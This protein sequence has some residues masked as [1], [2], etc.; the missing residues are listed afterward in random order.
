MSLSQKASSLTQLIIRDVVGVFPGHRF[1]LRITQTI[2]SYLAL[3]DMMRLSF[4]C[5]R[6]YIILGD[7]KILKRFQ[8]Y[9]SPKH[10][11]KGPKKLKRQ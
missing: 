8:E 9:N 11:T 10:N 1:K 7:C 3:L 5:K 6:F 2:I 4:T